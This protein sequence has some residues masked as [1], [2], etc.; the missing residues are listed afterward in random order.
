MNITI[1]GNQ[2]IKIKNLLEEKEQQLREMQYFGNGLHIADYEQ[3]KIDNQNYN[4]KIE[5]K[6]EELTNIRS[7]TQ[8]VIQNLANVR[9]KAYAVEGDIELMEE[10]MYDIET[11][12]LEVKQFI[13]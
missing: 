9:E 2:L 6:E 5:E 12:L 11:S 13:Y 3:M 8:T 7:K 4:D 1:S 10:K